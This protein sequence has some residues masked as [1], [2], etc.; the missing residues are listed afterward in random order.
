MDIPTPLTARLDADGQ[1][2]LMALLDGVADFMP[3]VYQA[4]VLDYQESRGDDSAL[5]GLRIYKHLRHEATGLAIAHP[6]IQ[7]AEPNGSYELVIG[8]LHIRIDG[9][10]HSR[11]DDVMV[12]FPDSSPTK[13]AAGESNY[14]QMRLEFPEIELTPSTADYSL[15]HLT[16]GHFGNPTEGLAKW[17]FGAW[18]ATET[19]G[20]Q[21]VWIHR[22]D[23]AAE[24]P[25]APLAARET[26]VPFSRRTADVV[27]LRP[28][29]SA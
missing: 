28:R 22:Q 12:C 26:V 18:R 3:R 11:H 19:G 6:G 20:R 1:S 4:A 9:L 27:S 25:E 29:P 23:V 10:G 13:V 8:P 21:W 16:I 24:A 15:N 2:L 7:L 5:F 17:Y 14:R